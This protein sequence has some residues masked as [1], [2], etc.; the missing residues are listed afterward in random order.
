MNSRSPRQDADH[1]SSIYAP[2]T[3][4]AVEEFSLDFS[5][6]YQVRTTHRAL[7]RYLQSKIEPHGV[8]L[9]MWYFLRVLWQQDGVTQ[10]D[11]SRSIGTMEPTTLS[12]ISSMERSGIVCRIRDEVDRRRQLVFLTKKGRA[13]KKDLLPLAVEVVRDAA[14]GLSLRETAML[15]DL[16]KA[17][18]TNLHAK[19]DEAELAGEDDA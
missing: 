16:L 15:L 9:G 2:A 14:A 11:L 4:G 19:I 10:S 17:V 5:I 1:L 18:Q 6:G 8:T 3:E 13:L 12:A 7:Q